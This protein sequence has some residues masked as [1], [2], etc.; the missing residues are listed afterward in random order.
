M[1]L[2]RRK[3]PKPRIQ[4]ATWPLIESKLQEDWSPEQISDWLKR[5]TDIQVSH[6]RIYLYI[7]VDK[8][9]GGSLHRHLHCQKKRRNRYCDNDRRGK[10]PNR[11]SIEERPEIVDQRGRIGDWE[12]DTIIGERH[13]NSRANP[14]LVDAMG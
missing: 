10:L 14:G 7:Y 12:L 1:S 5:N 2:N 4:E 6:E 11:R 8:R 9:A 13:Q 3:K